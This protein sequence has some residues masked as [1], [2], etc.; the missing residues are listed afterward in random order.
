MSGRLSPRAQGDDVSGKPESH[1]R[2]RGRTQKACDMCHQM[3]TKCDSAMPCRHCRQSFL[4]CSYSESRPKRRRN[5]SQ[6][7]KEQ[8][9]QHQQHRTVADEDTSQNLTAV[10]NSV[11]N[12]PDPTQPPNVA[13]RKSG[14]LKTP[15]TCP[16]SE[17]AIINGEARFISSSADRAFIQRLRTELGEWPGSDFEKRLAILDR[18]TPSFFP[19]RNAPPPVVPLPSLQR[20]RQL[21]NIALDAHILYQVIHRD[22]LECTFQLLFLLEQG[23]Y[24]EEETRHLP[25]VYVLLALG[26]IFEK[27]S[28]CSRETASDRLIEATGY[29]ETCRDL[30]DLEGCSQLATLQALFYMNMF[31]LAT[32]SLNSCYTSL[33]HVQTLVFRMNLHQPHYSNDDVIN[34]ELKRRLFWSTRQLL[35]I[36]TASTGLPSPIKADTFN[37]DLPAQ[38]E[39]TSASRQPESGT[40]LP[41]VDRPVL[42]PPGFLP[43][44]DLHNILDRVIHEMYPPAAVGTAQGSK[45]H[46]VS[47]ETVTAFGIQLKHWSN[48][49]PES[50]KRVQDVACFERANYELLMAYCHVQMY[51]HRPFLHYLTGAFKGPSASRKD[52]QK[53]ASACIEASRNIIHLGEDM[54]RNGL[55]FGAEWRIAHMIL[56]AALSL[57]YPPLSDRTS[58]LAT[59]V[60]T[61]LKVAKMLLNILRPYCVRARRGHLV[62]T[63]LTAALSGHSQPLASDQHQMR[64]FRQPLPDAPDPAYSAALRERVLQTPSYQHQESQSQDRA[65]TTRET[66]RPTAATNL[67]ALNALNGPTSLTQDGPPLQSSHNGL[68]FFPGLSQLQ[69]G[70]SMFAPTRIA[71]LAEM[72]PLRN[73]AMENPGLNPEAAFNESAYYLEAQPLSILQDIAFNDD[74]FYQLFGDGA[75][76]LDSTSEGFPCFGGFL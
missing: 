71:P 39:D 62:L 23:D 38:L 70:D 42:N 41:P 67:T 31:L 53:Y 34:K 43:Y 5:S 73:T 4:D 2:R 49:L 11:D 45:S 52:F 25:L 3:K 40:E 7:R 60:L 64:D 26:A 48:S 36:V 59:S 30:V 69:S 51:L 63:V 50:C 37:I 19:R 12:E 54:Y 14:N 66:A 9:Q 21:V 1:P 6:P 46:F 18:P 74:P 68:H 57:L 24:G 15:A 20:A 29:F 8:H 55:L 16:T 58:I 75:S 72:G 22:R 35:M 17:P 47:N 65:P 28:D 61:D 56:T 76:G 10:K 44:I 27:P 33:V 13:I 32:S